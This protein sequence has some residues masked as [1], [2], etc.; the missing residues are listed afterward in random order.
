MTKKHFVALAA[1]L[2]VHR[3]EETNIP[4]IRCWQSVVDEI[5]RVCERFNPAFCRKDF[6]KACDYIDT[7]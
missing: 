5:A 3:P 7:D 6:L 4:A 2:R 1:A